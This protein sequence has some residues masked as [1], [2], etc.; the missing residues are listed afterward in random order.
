MN[1]YLKYCHVTSNFRCVRNSLVA[2]KYQ[3][4]YLPTYCNVMLHTAEKTSL[5]GIFWAARRKVLIILLI[6]MYKMN[7]RKKGTKTPSIITFCFS[8]CSTPTH[9]LA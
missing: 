8:F 3:E 7:T 6:Q 4:C 2:Y 1:S 9:F 5:L